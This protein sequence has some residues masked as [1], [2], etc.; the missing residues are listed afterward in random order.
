VADHGQAAGRPA[1]LTVGGHGAADDGPPAARAT[2]AGHRGGPAR[3]TTRPVALVTGLGRGIGRA[4]AWALAEAGFDV[5]GCDLARDADATATL[6]GLA[7]RGARGAFV[8][9]DVAD[10]ESHPALLDAARALSGRVDCLVNNAGVPAA[11]RGDLLAL[12]PEDFDRVMAVNL[13]A[14]FFLAQTVARSMLD[15][16]A[17]AGLRSIVTV[18]SISATHASPERAEYCLSKSALPMMTQLLAL[19]LAPAG[20]AV[21]EV[22]PGIVRTPMTAP[23]APRYDAMIADGRV[24]ALRWGEPEDVGRTVAALAS[25]A[26]PFATGEAVH[27][28]GGLHVARL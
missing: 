12:R 21:W 4:I 6:D 10:L 25:G 13:R 11:R 24:P 14:P 2:P 20:I 8:A 17:P 16:P 9:C 26:L 18:S 28:D 7:R 19:R 15:D 3:A 22:R 5:A 1:A 27:V 23:V